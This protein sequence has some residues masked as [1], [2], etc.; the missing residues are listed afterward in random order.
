MSEEGNPNIRVDITGPAEAHC[1][2]L[3]LNP[4]SAPGACPPAIEIM[5]HARQLVD[6]IHK[7]SLALSDWQAA[8]TDHLLTRMG[9]PKD[10]RP[11]PPEDR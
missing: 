1:F 5:F 7:C 8:T 4:Q 2:R 11:S 10:R 6:L 3:T 9:V